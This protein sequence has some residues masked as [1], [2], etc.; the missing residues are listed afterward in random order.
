MKALGAGRLLT[1]KSQF[2]V[3]LTVPQCVSYALDRPAVASVLLGAQTVKEMETCLTYN[4][5][6]PQERDYST[7]LKSGIPLLSGKCM[8]CNHCLPCPQNIDIAS[9]T[10]YL[11]LAVTASD[12]Y[13]V[14]AHYDA[15][16]K[17]GG[18]CIECGKCA[19]VCPFNIDVIANMKEAVRTFG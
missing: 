3:P 14:R 6:T 19:S 2:G 17:N 5:S 9:V 7:V 11:D 13:T 16:P 12:S 1:D 18:D 15:L 10:K 4:K 8:Y